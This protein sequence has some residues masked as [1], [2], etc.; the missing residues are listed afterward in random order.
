MTDL[1]RLACLGGGYEELKTQLAYT[2]APYRYF[3]R[4]EAPPDMFMLFRDI[5]ERRRR[6][7]QVIE[8][9]TSGLG[10]EQLFGFEE[11]RRAG[12]AVDC[13]LRLPRS[14]SM[15]QTIHG[16]RDRLHIRKT[17]IGLGD[18]CSVRAHLWQ[19]KCSRVILATNDNTGLPACRLK[20]E[21]LFSTPLVYVSIGLPERLLALEAKRPIWVKRYRKWLSS[22]DL[23]VAY[24]YEEAEWLRQWLGPKSRVRF[25]P[26]GVDTE[27]WE[28][29]AAASKDVDVLSIG[30]DP[31]RDFSLLIAYARS[32][33]EVRVC[34]VTRS[35]CP[36]NLEDRPPN[37]QVKF[38][39]PI[40]ELKE[41][42]A[43]A[44]IVVLPVKENTYSGA[45]T[46]LL[47][48]MAMGKAVAVSRVGA[49]REGY[50]FMDGENLRW[51]EPGSAKSLLSVLDDMLAHAER[52]E[53]LGVQAR[54]HV[55]DQLNWNR[56]VA[57][58]RECLEMWTGREQGK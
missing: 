29:Q 15:W 39:L 31:M 40:K 51:L 54:R 16:W 19:I 1:G 14:T 57:N 32:R 38:Q 3:Q 43:A 47:Q 9:E 6:I 53:E 55:K 45:T 48:C 34:L 44:R 25:I 30:A 28:P 20:S 49:I 21:G 11:F 41:R 5:P 22:V 12:M 23:F 18:A 2:L 17:G 24:G 10:G 52:C 50:G 56:Y 58:L 26:F 27:K 7:Q 35:D 4:Q 13:N 8:D 36:V 42:I 46:T 37:L 33:P